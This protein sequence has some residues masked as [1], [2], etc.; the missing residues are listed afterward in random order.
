LII[1]KGKSVAAAFSSYGVQV[2]KPF[3]FLH[4]PESISTLLP[5]LAQLEKSTEQ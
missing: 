1:A 3:S 4:S 2:N 5:I